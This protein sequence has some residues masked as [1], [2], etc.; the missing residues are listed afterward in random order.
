MRPEEWQTVNQ[1]EVN[2]RVQKYWIW[3]IAYI[4][5]IILIAFIFGSLVIGGSVWF[6]SAISYL[7]NEFFAFCGFVFLLF[8]I[9]I[10]NSFQERKIVNVLN[11]ECDPYLYEACWHK[12]GFKCFKR[13]CHL[14]N[15]ATTV[16]H[17]GNMEEAWNILMQIRP[18]KLKGHF[19][20]HYYMLRSELY[21]RQGMGGQVRQLEDEFARRIRNRTDRKNMQRLCARNNGIRAYENKD[22]ES[23]YGFIQEYV[24]MSERS[25]MAE[26]VML[27]YRLALLD[28]ETGNM[29]A[30][31]ARL[32]YIIA[33]GNRLFFVREARQMLEQMKMDAGMDQAS[34]YHNEKREDQEE[35]KNEGE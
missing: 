32:K 2:K 6:A 4:I 3:K 10:L 13:D 1:Q 30:A 31:R 23:A 24:G 8:V 11:E 19:L 7:L 17:Q 5:G 28:K 14:Y 21:F 15:L 35:V 16:Y 20:A 34:V 18:E 9:C 33:N 26:R 25:I 27:S 12:T 22:Y 29:D